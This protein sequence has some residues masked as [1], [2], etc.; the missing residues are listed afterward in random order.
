MASAAAGVLKSLVLLPFLPLVLTRRMCCSPAPPAAAGGG[1][2]DGGD[3]AASSDAANR[4]TPT[5]WALRRP[6]SGKTKKAEKAL[7]TPSPRSEDA[8]HNDH[9]MQGSGYKLRAR[10]GRTGSAGSRR[11]S[12][13]A[14]RD[15]GHPFDDGGGGFATS[16]SSS[17]DSDAPD[18]DAPGAERSPRSPALQDYSPTSAEKRSRVASIEHN[19][20]F[21]H[22][23]GGDKD[24]MT[25]VIMAEKMIGWLRKIY[26]LGCILF[27]ALACEYCREAYGRGRLTYQDLLQDMPSQAITSYLVLSLALFAFRNDFPFNLVILIVCAFCAGRF[28]SSVEIEALVDE[29]VE[30]ARR[31]MESHANKGSPA[32]SM[33]AGNL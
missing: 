33:G 24:V 32:V 12:G 20:R 23:G 13:A 29:A 25:Q 18:S 1:A 19:S 28:S 5:R 17:P 8:D 2:G 22:G 3:E 14:R 21:I 31:V 10:R 7:I 30:A 6:S 27:V 16:S 9:N 4:S 26:W 15:D 11:G